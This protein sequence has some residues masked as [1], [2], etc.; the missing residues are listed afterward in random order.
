[1]SIVSHLFKLYRCFCHYTDRYLRDIAALL[2]RLLLA[3]VFLSSGLLKWN[4]WFDFNKQQYDL[5]L[6]QFFCPEP[7]RVGALQL[8]D[9]ETLEYQEGSLTVQF[10]QWFAVSAGI[11]EVLL[12][13]LLIIGLFTRIGALGLLFMTLLIQLAIFPSWEHWW[14]PAA[15]W[16]VAALLILARGPGRFSIDYIS[17]LDRR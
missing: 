15:W 11:F 6:Y 1:M 3:R 14:N 8:C 5:F 13:V 17:G 16:A 10:I 2:I 4:G 7:A 9:P 12:P